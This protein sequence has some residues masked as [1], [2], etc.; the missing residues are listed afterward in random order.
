MSTTNESLV[1]EKLANGEI[2]CVEC[3]KLALTYSTIMDDCFCMPCCLKLHNKGNRKNA[4]I[5][6]LDICSLCKSKAAKLECSYTHKL[7]CTQCFAMEHIKTLPP[8]GRES[9]PTLIMYAERAMG[10][11]GMASRCGMVGQGARERV[12]IGDTR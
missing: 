12:M 3:G 10:E 1:V 9:P 6:K 7:F 8:E 4:R 2:N 5:I 11:R